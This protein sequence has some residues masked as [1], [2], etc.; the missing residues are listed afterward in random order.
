V[1]DPVVLGHHIAHALGVPL[2]NG[3]QAVLKYIDVPLRIPTGLTA[4]HLKTIQEH[5]VPGVPQDWQLDE[6]ASKAVGGV[7]IRDVLAAL[8]QASLW[9][10]SWDAKLRPTS[11]VYKDKLKAITEVVFFCALMFICVPNAA[12][13]I[14]SGK[15]EWL[16]FSS[17]LRSVFRGY[18][19]PMKDST[20]SAIEREFG[21]TVRDVIESRM[22][23]IRYG[24]S[25]D[26]G[27]DI[28]SLKVGPEGTDVW[29]V[30]W[31]MLRS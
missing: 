15:R 9:L 26:V 11:Q 2:G 14:T 23:L 1:C 13:V 8:P 16:E 30:L 5:V 19:G 31:D 4:A 27:N 6:I 18:T 3:F 22:D 28:T 29:D 20:Q 12:Q 7:P 25:R 10:A 24:R 21:G 17:S